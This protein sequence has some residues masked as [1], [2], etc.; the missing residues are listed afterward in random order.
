[1]RYNKYKVTICRKNYS[2]NMFINH[3]NDLKEDKC[4]L[5]LE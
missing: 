1:M 3:L 4:P 5:I 2:K